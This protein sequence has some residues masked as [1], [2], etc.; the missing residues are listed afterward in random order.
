MSATEYRLAVVAQ[1]LGHGACDGSCR[2][3]GGK[4]HRGRNEEQCNSIEQAE[5]HG[6]RCHV[7]QTGNPVLE[8]KSRRRHRERVEQRGKR[9]Y[10]C[11]RSDVR[12]SG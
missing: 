9:E 12:S 11:E 6:F 5:H 4:Q 10:D 1:R 3:G 8:R 2:G 7:H